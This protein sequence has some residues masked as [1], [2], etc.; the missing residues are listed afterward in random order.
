MSRSPPAT[1][2]PRG[3]QRWA[4]FLKNHARGIIACDSARAGSL[5]G[6]AFVGGLETA[7]EHIDAM[8]GVV[9]TPRAGAVVETGEMTTLMVADRPMVRIRRVTARR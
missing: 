4:T 5:D 8:L 3:D 7:R 2:I 6:E 1:G 9:R